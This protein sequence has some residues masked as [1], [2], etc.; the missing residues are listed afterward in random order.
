MD[1]SNRLQ[2]NVLSV[3]AVAGMAAVLMSPSLGLYFNW[4]GMALNAG[5]VAPLVYF[6]CLLAT[7]PTAYCY[8]SVARQVPSAGQAYTWLWRAAGPKVGFWTGIV[9]M[10]FYMSTVW[11]VL[12]MFSLFFHDFL[13][14]LGAKPTFGYDILGLFIAVAF[15]AWVSYRKIKVNSQVSLGFLS[16]ETLVVFALGVV[17]FVTQL[18]RGHASLAP[19]N[20]VDT[21]GGFVGFRLAMIFGVL[22]FIGFDYAAVLAEEA[23][24]PKRNVPRAVLLAVVLVG[25]F[26]IVVSYALSIS[27]PMSDVAKYVNSGFT[28]VTPIAHLYMGIG[29]ILVIITGMSA[30]L[31]NLSVAVPGAARVLYAM[32]RD[33]SLPQVLGRVNPKTKVPSNALHVVVVAGTVIAVGMG[34]LQGNFFNAYVWFGTLSTMLALTVYTMVAVSS[35]LFYWR[36]ARD[37]FRV[38]QNAILPAIALL[39]N[40]YLMWESIISGLWNQPFA[41]GSSILYFGFAVW[42]G[43]LV[44]TLV[45]STR[46]PQLLVQTARGLEEETGT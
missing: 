15:V 20:P 4:G 46:K 18:V 21:V 30:S 24:T 14:Y 16:F 3:F 28:P 23:K 2:A 45:V 42:V 29:S 8:A 17:I 41:T 22:S 13:T 11:L 38:F 33:G 5:P 26:W 34:L 27:V 37:S 36:F 35:G 39:I 10:F 43:A 19:I 12:I 1:S 7:L 40:G 25:A 9:L 44:Y 6:A 31:G 32:G